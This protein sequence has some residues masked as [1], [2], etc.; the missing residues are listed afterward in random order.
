MSISDRADQGY[1]NK[2][3][4]GHEVRVISILADG[5]AGHG[6]FTIIPNGMHAGAFSDMLA[7]IPA[8]C[9]AE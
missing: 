7:H 4:A 3:M 1:R 2:A 8:N 9:P 5:G 6:I